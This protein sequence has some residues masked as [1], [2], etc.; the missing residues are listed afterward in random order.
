MKLALVILAVWFL[1]CVPVGMLAGNFLAR[2][3]TNQD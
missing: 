2:R 3:S 1:L